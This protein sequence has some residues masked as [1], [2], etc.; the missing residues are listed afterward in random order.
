MKDKNMNNDELIQKIIKFIKSQIGLSLIQDK[1]TY[2]TGIKKHNGRKYFNV[3]LP[4]RVSE[5]NEYDLLERFANK[6]KL[7][8]VEPN[9]V[10]RVAIFFDDKILSHLKENVIIKT[11]QKINIKEMIRRIIKEEKGYQ[12]ISTESALNKNP[13][14][15]Q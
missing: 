7:I 8:S 3:E 13:I 2:F 6:F 12:Q 10:N 4:V 9:G 11:K 14:H 1:D 15:P 5:S